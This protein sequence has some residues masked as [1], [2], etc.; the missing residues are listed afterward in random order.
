MAAKDERERKK[1]ERETKTH[2][3]K[4]QKINKLTLLLEKA[5]SSLTTTP[6]SPKARNITAPC[7]STTADES[8]TF[9]SNKSQCYNCRKRYSSSKDQS[10]WISCESRNNWI[11]RSCLPKN[12]RFDDD[13]NA[14][15][16]LIK[17]T[18]KKKILKKFFFT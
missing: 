9:M 1:T 6:S 10:E 8:E 3:L 14:Q 7:S 16:V 15:N 13:L 4:I 11:C 17:K 5:K 12:F 2:N 18:F